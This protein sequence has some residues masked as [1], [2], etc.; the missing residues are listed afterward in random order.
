M[1]VT[2]HRRSKR[3][4][5]S[6]RG[7]KRSAR[8][9]S[10]R[11]SR[12]STRK[13]ISGGNRPTGVFFNSLVDFYKE[14]YNGEDFY[15]LYHKYKHDEYNYRPQDKA[16]NNFTIEIK[17]IAKSCSGKPEE[18]HCKINPRDVYLDYKKFKDVYF[19]FIKDKEPP[20]KAYNH[21]EYYG[22]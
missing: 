7:G 11:S 16:D 4:S 1:A 19:D 12:R 6:K 10:R 20:A 13:R 14:R 21:S 17:N 8:R 2:R 15:D 18:Q 22:E 5:S 9:S 3:K